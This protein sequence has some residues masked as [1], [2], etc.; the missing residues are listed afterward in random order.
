MDLNNVFPADLESDGLLDEV[1]K[2]HVFGYAKFTPEGWKIETTNDYDVMRGL[3]TNPSNT[4][5][6]HNG[7]R[8][9]KPVLEKIL[10]I[11]V[12]ATI[13]DSLSLSWWMWPNRTKKFGLEEFGVEYGVE[14]PKIDDW[15]NLSYE[16]YC[17][18]IKNDIIINTKLW[19]D[20]IKKARQLYDKDEEIVRL[21]K[22][23][24]FIMECSFNQEVQKVKV[25]VAKTEENLRYFESL[26]EEKTAALKKAMP[27]AKKYAIK[28]I[29]K[30]LYKKDGSLSVAGE[31]WFKRLDE[32][33]LPKDT[34]E[35]EDLVSE[36]EPNPN[37]TD[38]KK[39]WLYSLGWEPETFEYKRDK[40]NPEKPVR[41]I[42]Q[43]LTKEKEL[44]PSVLRLID[45]E[46][47]IEVL[48][49]LTVLTHRIGT[50]KG[51]LSNRDESDMIS[52]GLTRLA[53]TM[54]WQ[55]SVIVNIPRV[56]GKKDLR[57]G[58]WLRECL[59]ANEGTRLI[60]AD[61]SGIESRTSD[62]FTFKI[63]PDR[64]EKTKKPYFD[65]HTEISVIAGLMTPEEEAFYVFNS[66]KNDIDKSG[67]DSSHLDYKN[68]S[69]YPYNEEVQ[70]LHDLPKEEKYKK[71]Q[72]L[73]NQRT[74]G[75]TTN[76]SCKYKVGAKTLS[77]TLG[78]DVATAQNLID[79]YWEVHFAVKTAAERFKT[80]KVGDET[81][82]YN[83]VSRFWYYLR[84]DKD[85]FSVVNSSASVYLFNLWVLF[86]TKRVGFPITQT[87]DDLMLR[88]EDKEETVKEVMNQVRLAIEDV[89]KYVKLNVKIDC[90]VQSG[91]KFSDTH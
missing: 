38:Q 22:L 57:D 74:K 48:E 6:I 36:Q 11:E 89:N 44:C 39:D 85:K 43:I 75:K 1:T 37:S 77:R 13:I 49:G 90:E 15:N 29:P 73:K 28:K 31:S 5:V 2:I 53:V 82:I 30:V 23:L 25:D 88:V 17:H 46:P 91:Y 41:T 76:Y 64:I 63:N 16:A 21:I 69:I 14:K 24:N 8:Y 66:V 42:P 50:L 84:N 4:F 80:K 56:T 51:F 60:Q 27:M 9:D 72:E 33:H 18:R 79:S 87:H 20:L 35:F 10:D 61:L 12:K 62:H 83:P 86:V 81:W 78:V 47:A 7:M 58:I 32:L 55:H 54:R 67:G 52:Q 68:F 71:M 59:I 3:L 26:K 19:V 45:K 70:R 34:Q 40:K 65:E